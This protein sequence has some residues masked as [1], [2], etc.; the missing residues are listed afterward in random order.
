[1]NYNDF[2]IAN[3]GMFSNDAVASVAM[4][5][6]TG[7]SENEAKKAMQAV[8]AFAVKKGLAKK[9]VTKYTQTLYKND[10]HT[11]IGTG[12]FLTQFM[13][14]WYRVADKGDTAASLAAE[15][16]SE[17]AIWYANMQ[18]TTA[19]IGAGV[20]S[21]LDRQNR[22]DAA[23][24]GAAQVNVSNYNNVSARSYASA[25]CSAFDDMDEAADMVLESIF[26]KKSLDQ[27]S[28]AYLKQLDH[29]LK[30]VEDCDELLA[31]IK[32]DAA[33]FNDN[34]QILQTAKAKYEKNQISLEEF[35][36]TTRK[37]SHEI[38]SCCKTFKLKLS[39]FGGGGINAKSNI[40]K[41]DIMNFKSYLSSVI[42]G[43]NSIKNA[44]ER[45]NKTDRA[46]ESISLGSEYE[47]YKQD[48]NQAIT[49]LEILY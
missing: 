1:M 5:R 30:T 4:F 16:N 14:R 48:F 27:M 44:R 28:S 38:S 37:A 26:T 34:L 19:A 24:A 10:L 13:E 40:T 8:V 6:N 18:N 39:D 35:K 41:E 23:R 22:I 15:L 46:S 32:I 21:A 45:A 3:E 49:D 47:K 33:K 42:K 31:K 11:I 17:Y 20:N 36:I 9:S 25:Y 2:D 29:K 43:I 12:A 7:M